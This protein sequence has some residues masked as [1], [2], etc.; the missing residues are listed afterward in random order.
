[1]APLLMQQRAD[2]HALTDLAERLNQRTTVV[3][4]RALSQRLAA[5]SNRTGL[6][7]RLKT[8]IEA[9]SGLSLDD[10]RVHYDS[11][12][13]SQV[14]AHAY[15]QG[16]DIHVAPGQER[17]LPH[18]AWHVV[19][20]KERRVYPTG[21]LAAGI[22]LNDDRGLE[23]EADRMGAA[24]V[25][26]DENYSLERPKAQKVG[27]GPVQRVKGDGLVITADDTE[28][29]QTRSDKAKVIARLEKGSSAREL[30]GRTDKWVKVTT[31]AEKPTTGW[32]YS[33]A[34][35]TQPNV[36]TRGG[37]VSEYAPNSY[38][39]ILRP[40]FVGEPSSD[41]I[42]Q[43]GI[44]DC[45]LLAPLAAI[46]D[47]PEGK[48][49]IKAMI[50]PHGAA[51]RY[52]VRFFIPVAGGLTA[53]RHVTVDNWFAGDDPESPDF[54]QPVE[55]KG[56]WP[57][58][59]EKAVAEARGGLDRISGGSIDAAHILITG[60]PVRGYAFEG[61][62]SLIDPTETKSRDEMWQILAEAIEHDRSVTAHI[63]PKEADIT[64]NIL[65]GE[66]D[67]WAIIPLQHRGVTRATLKVRYDIGGD[68]VKT[69]NGG[70]AGLSITKGDNHPDLIFI[71]KEVYVSA[72]GPATVKY[73]YTNINGITGGH[74]YAV[75][76]ID[77]DSLALVDPHDTSE[78]TELSIDDVENV[79]D[80]RFYV[81]STRVD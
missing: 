48:G 71:E 17:H 3:A 26:W 34:A 36:L 40:A 77:E 46:A 25:R 7:D 44:G 11:P 67:D 20:Q 76:S 38:V 68:Q 66:D 39:S 4:Q 80:V 61:E 56:I 16:S 8:G 53:E 78:I 33:E 43:G 2:S 73:S 47:T 62:N 41:D 32:I 49:T 69:Y 13:P 15:T 63:P 30:D 72:T 55:D 70:D 50:T 29:R 64:T 10:V 58:I 28:V 24:A 19:Q 79:F 6:P 81:G 35:S 57:L 5:R 27:G 14:Q 74:V 52:T 21:Q 22:P 12:E 75:H 65:F 45:W 60:K 18:E 1:L 42:A 31:L 9:L 23:D 54:A 37:V 51:E 59:V